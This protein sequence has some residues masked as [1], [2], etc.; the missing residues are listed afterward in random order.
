[1]SRRPATRARAVL[2]A[3][4]AALSL[5]L[6]VTGWQFVN[7]VR[8]LATN[9]GLRAADHLAIGSLDVSK[10]NWPSSEVDAYYDRIFD[11]IRQLPNVGNVS[12]SCQ[13]SPWGFWQSRGG[14][15]LSIWQGH[16]PP[17]KPGR[18]LAMYSGGDLFGALGLPVVA[19]RGFR[20]EERHGP[21]RSVIVNQPFVDKYL[22]SQ[23]VGESL[24]VAASTD[25]G[26]SQPVVIVGVVQP[27]PTRRTDSLPIVYYPTPLADMPARTLYVRFAVPAADSIGLLHAAIREVNA[28]APRPHILTAEQDRWERHSA[29]QLLAAA[30]SSFGVLAL[31]LATGGLYGIVAFVVTLRRHE[32]AVRMALG[33][34]ASEVV[35]MIVRQALKPAAIGAAVGLS[36]AVITGLIVRSRLYGASPVDPVAFAGAA[37]L[38]FAVLFAATIVPARRAANVNPITVLRQE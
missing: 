19:G 17:E 13:C 23:P 28:D 32:I 10:L 22:G 16:H 9:D 25:F 33:A 15:S 5:A 4:Q 2:I 7:T 8:A 37:S 31:L 26:D 14:G 38:L 27:P 34:P 6:M 18:T 29:N 11:R 36:A 21:V 24:R 12:Y 20:P 3:T 35:G 1:M 30:V